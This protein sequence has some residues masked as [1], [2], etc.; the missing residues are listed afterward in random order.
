MDTTYRLG[1]PERRQ[2]SA[3]TELLVISI[4]GERFRVRQYPS[5][6]AAITAWTRADKALRADRLVQQDGSS[7]ERGIYV[8]SIIPKDGGTYLAVRSGDDPGWNARPFLTDLVII[9]GRGIRYKREA[10]VAL[11]RASGSSLHGHQGGWLYTGLRPGSQELWQDRDAGLAGMVAQQRCPAR[12]PADGRRLQV[13]PDQPDRGGG[14]MST[15]TSTDVTHGK[16]GHRCST[17]CGAAMLREADTHE[18]AC[19]ARHPESGGDC[20][21][22][23]HERVHVT[24]GIYDDDCGPCE[25]S[26]AAQTRPGPW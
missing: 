8:G 16:P 24:F 15:L 17:L 10:I 14:R 6:D 5:Y 1:R 2:T 18:P 21:C 20:Q 4:R 13:P 12:R 19:P 7:S 22:E 26:M 23:L 11:V 3:E 25:R 9:R